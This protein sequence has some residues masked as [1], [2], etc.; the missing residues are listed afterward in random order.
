MP[1]VTGHCMPL[2]VSG[3]NVS[4]NLQMISVGQ[5]AEP[6]ML[7]ISKLSEISIINL[8]TA[9][10]CTMKEVIYIKPSLLKINLVQSFQQQ[11]Y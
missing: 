10:L 2:P 3:T 1:G 11:Y 5:G 8:E 6:S 4:T 7:D 9:K